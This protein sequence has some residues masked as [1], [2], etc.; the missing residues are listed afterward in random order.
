VK[1]CQI[2]E[3][4]EWHE[5]FPGENNPNALREPWSHGPVVFIVYRR[6]HGTNSLTNDHINVQATKHQQAHA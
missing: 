2:H 1:N 4:S 6:S 3:T 5:R